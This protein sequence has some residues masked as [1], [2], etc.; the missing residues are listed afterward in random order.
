MLSEHAL[1]GKYKW[2]YL[3]LIALHFIASCRRLSF[4]IGSSASTAQFD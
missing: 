4:L 2:S 3:K 1:K